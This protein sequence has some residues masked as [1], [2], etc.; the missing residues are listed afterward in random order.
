MLI[1]LLTLTLTYN[2]TLQGHQIIYIG[3]T[4]QFVYGITEKSGK[5]AKYICTEVDT[6]ITLNIPIDTK[7]VHGPKIPPPP[8]SELS[9]RLCPLAVTGQVQ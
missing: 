5:S 4:Y 3:L 6:F 7:K 8:P 2:F 1:S 9:L